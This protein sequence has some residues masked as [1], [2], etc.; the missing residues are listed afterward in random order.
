[1]GE[2]F[3]GKP[4]ISIRACGRAGAE[5]LVALRGGFPEPPNKLAA[6]EPAPTSSDEV[7]PASAP[8]DTPS[9]SAGGT[10][11]AAAPQEVAEPN[12]Q[13][14]EKLLTLASDRGVAIRQYLEATYGIDPERVPECRT[15]YSI[16]DGKSPRAEFQF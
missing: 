5:D 6:P 4:G 1:M 12:E 8:S 2:L 7:T 14:V 9:A 15:A 3:A 16:K 10:S 13:E 11:A